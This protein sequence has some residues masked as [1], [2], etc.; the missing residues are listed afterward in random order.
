[1]E[2]NFF[3]RYLNNNCKGEFMQKKNENDNS[4]LEA[5]STFGLHFFIWFTFFLIASLIVVMLKCCFEI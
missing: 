4:V 2:N 5:L 3:P 1:M